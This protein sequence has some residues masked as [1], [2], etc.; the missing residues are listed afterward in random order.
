MSKEY[1]ITKEQ[2]DAIVSPHIAGIINAL[3]K[4]CTDENLSIPKFNVRVK[5]PVNEKKKISLRL[6]FDTVPFKK[7]AR[8]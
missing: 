1:I 5:L 4:A 8:K 2:L 7:K 6:Y 3:Y